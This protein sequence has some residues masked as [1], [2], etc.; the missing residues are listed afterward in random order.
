[1]ATC[2]RVKQ[3][4]EEKYHHIYCDDDEKRD[5]E[6]IETTTTSAPGKVASMHGAAPF[7]CR[8]SIIKRTKKKEKREKQKSPSL[9]LPRKGRREP[10]LVFGTGW[11][12]AARHEI[13]PPVDR[14]AL[15]A[16]R[17]T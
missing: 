11:S 4:G 8:Q 10:N 16:A 17:I 6:P 14:R 5:D 1:V 7:R 9:A 12:L 2:R 13:R 15:A 3:V